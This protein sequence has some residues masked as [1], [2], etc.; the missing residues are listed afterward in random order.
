[1]TRPDGIDDGHRMKSRRFPGDDQSV[2]FSILK[3]SFTYLWTS[4][5]GIGAH[6][7]VDRLDI[8]CRPIHSSSLTVAA[9][10]HGYVQ[11]NQTVDSIVLN[12]KHAIRIL[13]PI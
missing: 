1:M 10:M 6:K 3:N 13:F 7:P 2:I 5:G 12:L 8:K 4:N 9:E 11:G